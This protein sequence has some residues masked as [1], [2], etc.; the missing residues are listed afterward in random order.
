MLANY[1]TICARYPLFFEYMLTDNEKYGI[2]F[3]IKNFNGLKELSSRK[4]GTMKLLKLYSNIKV[5]EDPFLSNLD[6][7]SSPL[8]LRYIELLLTNDIFISQLN[9][10]QKDSLYFYLSEK[11][12]EKRKNLSVYQGY[13][14]LEMSKSKRMKTM[15]DYFTI[16]YTR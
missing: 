14:L 10:I 8:H 13:V 4:D 2:S 3:M 16:I 11:A 15:S 1:L 9:D 7:L 5:L 12:S 6:T